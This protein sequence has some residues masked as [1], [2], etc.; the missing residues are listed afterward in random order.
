MKKTW[1]T[2]F[3]R[4]IWLVTRLNTPQMNLKKIRYEIQYCKDFEPCRKFLAEELAVHL[5][6]V[7]K[8][9]KLVNLRLSLVFTNLFR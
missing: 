6:I 8:T 5:I 4:K 2:L 3:V 1:K 9:V 7:I